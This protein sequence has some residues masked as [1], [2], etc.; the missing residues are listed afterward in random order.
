ARKDLAMDHE[1]AMLYAWHVGLVVL[2]LSGVF[3]IICAPLGNLVR[4]WVPRAGLLGS[5]AAI[6]LTLI[7]FM[8]LQQDIARMPVVGMLAL[9][10]ILITL[11]AHRRLPGNFPGALAAVLVGVFVYLLSTQFGSSIGIP[12]P[13]PTVPPIEIGWPQFPL[14]P[15]GQEFSGWWGEVTVA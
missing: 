5:L 9:V 6:A 2:V 1:Q 13:A 11:V 7:A 4:K 14:T 15:H 8:P 10:V 3:K 12:V